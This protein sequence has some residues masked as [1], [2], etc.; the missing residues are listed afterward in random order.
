[1]KQGI[2]I[3]GGGYRYFANAWV[4]AGLLKHLGSTLPLEVW[5]HESE[6]SPRIQK[7]ADKNSLN[8]RVITKLS[9][10][11][12]NVRG[13]RGRWQWGLK[14]EAILQCDY[15]QLIFMDADNFA[16]RSPDYLLKTPEFKDTGAIFW[17]DIQETE[18]DRPIWDIMGVPWRLEPEFETGQIVLDREKCGEP[19]ELALSP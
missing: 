14:L 7:L 11:K 17:P 6:Y 12:P 10:P 5:M 2:V 15:E 19:L 9:G 3:L 4:A 8:I 13:S 16:A 18:K 1:M